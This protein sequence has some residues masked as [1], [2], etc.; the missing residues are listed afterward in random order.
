M[1][2]NKSKHAKVLIFSIFVSIKHC[3]KKIV[4]VRIPNKKTAI[5]Q[6]L[7]QFCKAAC[8]KPDIKTSARITCVP[9]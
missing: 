1:L 9:N 6:S 2:C 5:S 7:I 4:N 8:H 3:G